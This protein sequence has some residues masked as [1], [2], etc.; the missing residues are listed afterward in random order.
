[1]KV[2]VNG[3]LN[4]S[5]LDGWWAEAYSPEVGWAI[6]M[7]ANMGMTLPGT[8]PMLRIFMRYSKERLSLSFI[9]ATSME[10]HAAGLR[11]CAKAWPA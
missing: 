2:L 1:M 3:G 9:R 4:L 7:G 10:F 5:E 11:A 8:Q 6:E